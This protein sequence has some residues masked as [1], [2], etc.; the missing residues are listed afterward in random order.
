M[1][2]LLSLLDATESQNNP[3][4]VQ[5]KVNVVKCSRKTNYNNAKGESKVLYHL[6][7]ADTTAAIK[8]TC[9]NEEIYSHTKPSYGLLISNF[10]LNLNTMVITKR[11]KVSRVTPLRIPPNMQYQAEQLLGPPPLPMSPL[12]T[13][14]IST[15]KTLLSV[16]GT[17]QEIRPT[18]VIHINGQPTEVKTIKIQD[19]TDSI[20]V[21]LWREAAHA[22]V[23]QGDYL[24]MS[25]VKV[26]QFNGENI[27]NT[28]RISRLKVTAAP[29][30]TLHIEIVGLENRQATSLTITTR[31]LESDTLQS[32]DINTDILLNFLLIE[33]N[34]EK[35]EDLLVNKLPV[36]CEIV[37][38]NGKIQEISKVPPNFKYFRTSSS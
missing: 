10:I 38:C 18:R 12:K 4:Q 8:A 35:F 25:N 23:S 19:A 28:T 37:F 11:T 30:E 36:E 16:A 17:V 33:P 20:K 24:L 22:D 27:L 6:A 2:S 14:K 26:S 5:V 32:M 34:T 1:L 3:N 31:Q 15:I 29:P 21:S 7:L 13:A 9:Y